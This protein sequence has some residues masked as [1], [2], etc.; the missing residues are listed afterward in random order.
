MLAAR[1]K[2]LD[3]LNSCLGTFDEKGKKGGD[4]GKNRTRDGTGNKTRA[5]ARK[6]KGECFNCQETGHRKSE[7]PKNKIT[8]RSSWSPK[9]KQEESQKTDKS[10]KSDMKCNYCL[11][12]GHSEERCYEKKTDQGEKNENPWL[13]DRA[14][15]LEVCEVKRDRLNNPVKIVKINKIEIECILILEAHDQGSLSSEV[16]LTLIP[17]F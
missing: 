17:T 9:I 6:I 12:S 10:G 14:M 11:K 2:T 5:D 3:E 8:N 4:D 13:D 16:K 1:L 7:C 15:S